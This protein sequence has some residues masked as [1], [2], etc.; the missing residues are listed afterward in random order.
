[1]W[2]FSP[3]RLSSAKTKL[4]P[5]YTCLPWFFCHLPLFGRHVTSLNKCLSLGWEAKT[6]GTRLG[7][8]V[9]FYNGGIL[10]KFRM[11]VE[12]YW[13]VN[14]TKNVTKGYYMAVWRCKISLQV[15]KNIFQ[16][17]KRNFV[18]P[19]GHVMYRLLHKYP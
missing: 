14:L 2:S 15:L 12:E 4:L 6:L 13:H 3:S 9:Y 11:N 1:M 5:G 17:K 16:H 10:C 7:D 8:S 19:P 18:Y